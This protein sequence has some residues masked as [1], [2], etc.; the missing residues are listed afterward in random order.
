[1]DTSYVGCV[2]AALRRDDTGDRELKGDTRGEDRAVG[3][4][5]MLTPS[6]LQSSSLG[7]QDQAQSSTQGLTALTQNVISRKAVH[8]IGARITPEEVKR[9]VIQKKV[10]LR[11]GVFLLAKLDADIDTNAITMIEMKLKNSNALD[12]DHGEK[13]GIWRSTQ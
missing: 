13:T 10:Q 3:A 7:F 4:G 6:R 9:F 12:Q 2:P 11:S 8:L 1:M 5:I